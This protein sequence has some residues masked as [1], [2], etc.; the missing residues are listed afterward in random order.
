MSDL[1][2]KQ[3]IEAQ[4]NVWLGSISLAQPHR[5]W[6][7]T[8]LASGM[9]CGLILFLIFGTYTQ[10]SRVQG[11][12]VPAQGLASVI[13]P[14]SGVMESVTV[15]EGDP[16]QE[17]QVLGLIRVPRLTVGHGDTSAALRKIVQQRRASL[18]GNQAAQQDRLDVDEASLRTQLRSLQHELI[19]LQAE[20]KTRQSQ[21]RLANE[22]LERMRR[23]QSDK[24]VS[25]IQIKQQEAAALDRVS[26]S[27]EVER[28]ASTLQRAAAQVEQA[29]AQVPVQRAST[30]AAHR[31]DLAKLSQEEIDIEGA[32]ALRIAAPTSGVVA[33]QV[34]KPGQAVQTG[35]PLFTLLPEG[36]T[37]RAELLVPSR[38]IPTLRPGGIVLLRYEAF[39]YQKF[40]HH[41]GHVTHIGRNALGPAETKAL[42]LPDPD[43]QPLYRVI[44]ALDQQTVPAY[45]RLEP[46][47]PGMV[48]DA[49]LLGDTRPL[50]QWLFEPL[51]SLANQSTANSYR[52]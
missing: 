50:F 14:A 47:R 16:I 18:E 52:R 38:A 20:R 32:G 29:L 51:Y 31:G 49:D 10:R 41:I 22:V 5:T 17:Q 3:V 24:Y 23:L 4:S 27:Q 21:A 9:G 39:S 15:T 45:G 44:V 37:L 46:L 42:D 35:Q 7:L 40:G 36:S 1:F 30:I 26:A 28:Q 25:D 13:A 19:Q 2:R 34:I 48:V 12:L 43:R 11:R 6:V 8:L 33:T